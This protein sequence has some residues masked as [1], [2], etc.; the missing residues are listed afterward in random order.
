MKRYQISLFMFSVIAVLAVL[1][2][3]FPEEGW[4]GLRF[5]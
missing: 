4:L 5:P 3:I 2:A 1:C